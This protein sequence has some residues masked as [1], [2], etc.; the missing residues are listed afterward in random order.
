MAAPAGRPSKGAQNRGKDR[1]GGINKSA[2]RGGGGG[3]VDH[4]DAPS[5]S[6]G[7]VSLD[8]MASRDEGNF[9]LIIVAISRNPPKFS[10]SSYVEDLS[11][12]SFSFTF[13]CIVLLTIGTQF[14]GVFILT[15]YSRLDSCGRA[16]DSDE[17]ESG[18][19]WNDDQQW[20][21]IRVIVGLSNSGDKRVDLRCCSGGLTMCNAVGDGN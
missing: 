7:F 14:M 10:L 3:D 20:I 19:R 17:K 4:R 16:I 6:R 18:W 9:C 2:R 8:L 21:F 15:F 12:F 11:S 1:R 13:F 5:S